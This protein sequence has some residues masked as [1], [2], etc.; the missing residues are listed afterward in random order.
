MIGEE[1]DRSGATIGFLHDRVV[2]KLMV[3]FSRNPPRQNPSCPSPKMTQKRLLLIASLPLT[4]ALTGRRADDVAARNT[5]RF[6]RKCTS[7]RIHRLDKIRPWLPSQGRCRRHRCRVRIP[8]GRHRSATGPA[9]ARNRTAMPVTPCQSRCRPPAPPASAAASRPGAAP[10][11]QRA[12]VPR[13]PLRHPAADSPV[14]PLRRCQRPIC[15]FTQSRPNGG[16]GRPDRG[17]EW[18]TRGL[19]EGMAMAREDPS[20]VKIPARNGKGRTSISLAISQNLRATSGVPAVSSRL[21]C[22]SPTSAKSSPCTKPTPRPRGF[23]SGIALTPRHAALRSLALPGRPIL[24]LLLGRPMQVPAGR[25]TPSA[26]C[27][28]RRRL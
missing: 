25:P 7:R 6:P 3:R 26:R 20:R 27:G 19:A 17:T 16:Q 13:R 11:R 8:T 18:P 28:C 4:I 15:T 2:F 10:E 5:T 9:S 12:P 23:R 24:I 14:T 21:F 22:P 1:N